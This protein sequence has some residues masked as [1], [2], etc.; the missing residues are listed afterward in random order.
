MGGWLWKKKSSCPVECHWQQCFLLK[1]EEQLIYLLPVRLMVLFWIPS[2]KKAEHYGCASS[3]SITATH[4]SGHGLRQVTLKC[5]PIE[6]PH[7]LLLNE[8]KLGGEKKLV[9]QANL[10]VV[11]YVRLRYG[12]WWYMS[13]FS[14][15]MPFLCVLSIPV[16]TLVR[17][18]RVGIQHIWEATA[19]GAGGMRFWLW[20]VLFPVQRTSNV[21]SSFFKDCLYEVFDD[22]ES[23]MEDTGKQLLR[24]VLHL[25]EDGAL[26][27]T[28]NFDNLL[29]IYAAD[30][31]KHLESLDLTDEKKV[32]RCP[33]SCPKS[34]HILWSSEKVSLIS[35]KW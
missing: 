31:G 18:M 35:P 24:S 10:T 25:M 11:T 21:R 12:V 30:Q 32:K 16:T 28:T 2:S 9:A 7:T 17:M 8:L 15:P 34:S 22:L 27:L 29:E 6:D 23:K 1:P 33:A 5:L 19:L 14:Y 13:P 20:C 3:N 4:S 26:V